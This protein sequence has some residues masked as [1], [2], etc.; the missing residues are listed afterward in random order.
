MGIQIMVFHFL[1]QELTFN[2][3]F[4]KF[5]LN[6]VKPDIEDRKSVSYQLHFKKLSPTHSRISGISP[7]PLHF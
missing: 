2:H 5:G 1:F 7:L 3:N 6:I 4:F